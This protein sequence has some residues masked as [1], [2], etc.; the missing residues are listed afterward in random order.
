MTRQ[1]VRPQR[2]ARGVQI[3]LRRDQH[4]RAFRDLA[5]FQCGIGGLSQKEGQVDGIL[6]DVDVAVGQAQA[7]LDPRIVGAEGRDQRRDQPPSQAQGR[8]QADHTLRLARKAADQGLGLV[9]GLDHASGVVIEGAADLGRGQL[10]GGAVQQAQAKAVFQ[11]LD[12]VRCDCGRQAQIAPPRRDRAQFD[13]PHEDPQAFKIG[14]RRWPAFNGTW[15][16]F[17]VADDSATET[18]ALA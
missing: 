1:V 16:V 14:H 3:G 2:R 6:D 10:A 18:V 13:H 4:P 8:G 9:Q 15:K 17:Y 7:D 5:P 12:P 11:I